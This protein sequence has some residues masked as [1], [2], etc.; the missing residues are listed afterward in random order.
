MEIKVGS[1][2][3]MRNGEIAQVNEMVNGGLHFIGQIPGYG[4]LA[5]I[6]CKIF[7]FMPLRY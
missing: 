2:Y 7:S 4:D 5:L 3:E 1:K 6:A